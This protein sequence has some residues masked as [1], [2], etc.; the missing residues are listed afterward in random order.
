MKR[1]RASETKEEHEE[2]VKKQ[3]VRRARETPQE[4][5][6]RLSKDR[7]RYALYRL[8]ETEEE[9]RVR[10]SK[11]REHQAHSR[12]QETEAEHIASLSKRRE[13]RRE[14]AEAQQT[15]RLAKDRS[16]HRPELQFACCD[17]PHRDNERG[18]KPNSPDYT[19]HTR[20]PVAPPETCFLQRARCPNQ[21][22]WY[23][24]YLGHKQNGTTM[25]NSPKPDLR[26]LGLE[27]A[28][29][30][31]DRFRKSMSSAEA[32]GTC[33]ACAA[34]TSGLKAWDVEELQSLRVPEVCSL[35]IECRH[36]EQLTKGDQL[37]WCVY[38]YNR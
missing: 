8:Q 5:E 7:K 35:D 33:A 26:P 6:E 3:R 37:H 10:L 13:S 1:R 14:E 32:L 30:L 22:A 15:A 11:K 16:N 31:L 24:M 28:Q 20:S 29:A 18:V 2:R 23:V 17:V 21:A 19:L 4:K 34:F 38:I 36:L 9:K 12:G 27:E 25:Y